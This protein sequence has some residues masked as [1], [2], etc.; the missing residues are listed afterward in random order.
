[1]V[2]LVLYTATTG[3]KAQQLSLDVLAN[4]LSNVNTSGYKSSF[5]AFADLAYIEKTRNA[6]SEEEN[7]VYPM[8]L[9][10]GTGVRPLAI[11]RVNTQGALTETGMPL[12]VAISGKG[13]FV[14]RD[15][16]G[17]RD[18]YTRS[19]M[20]TKD[21]EGRIVT[22][23]GHELI[24]NITITEPVSSIVIDDSGRV[25]EVL[26]NIPTEVGQIDLAKFVNEAGL[27]AV[28]SNLFAE[29]TASGPA[30]IEEPNQS[31]M[32]S[33]VQYY[34]ESSNVDALQ[35]MLELIKAQRSY[36]MV[37]KVINTYNALEK[38]LVSG[39]NSA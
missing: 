26:D 13:Y 9:K 12:N 25:F 31:D 28:G 15:E 33:L 4:D 36:E 21:A 37:L 16:R 35:S 29:T 5:I 23:D 2:D 17:G 6:Q 34:L 3:L 1:M 32:G 27:E 11:T 19:G 7:N 18:L 14:V 30:I 22:P 20:F 8:N 24:P 10:V 39:S 38:Q